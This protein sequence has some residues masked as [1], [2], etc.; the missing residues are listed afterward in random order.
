MN[1]W[2]PYIA[3]G[4]IVIGAVG[5]LGVVGWAIGLAIVGVVL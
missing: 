5:F 4:L 1:E 3:I 2:I